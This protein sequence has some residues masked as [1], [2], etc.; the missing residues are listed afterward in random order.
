MEKVYCMRCKHFEGTWF[1]GRCFHSSNMKD[2]WF[3]SEKNPKKLPSELN[4]NNDCE[5]FSHK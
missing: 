4:K 3:C 1:N 5:F 2:D